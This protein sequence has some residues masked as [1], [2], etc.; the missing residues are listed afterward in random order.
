MTIYSTRYQARK[1]ARSY[2]IV[3]KVF[4]GYTVMTADAYRVWRKQK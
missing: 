2:E 1:A 4:G 3:V